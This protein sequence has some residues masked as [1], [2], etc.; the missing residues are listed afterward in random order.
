MTSTINQLFS[1][2]SLFVFV[3]SLISFLGY[4]LKKDNKITDFVSRN[5]ILSV[6]LLSTT[7]VIG[8]LTYSIGLG[9]TPCLLCWYQRIFM[10]PIALLSLVSISFNKK[11]D[12]LFIW[13]LILVGFGF[14]L[15]HVFITYTGISPIPCPA[16]ISCTVRYVYEFGFMTIP[17]MSF[18]FF[19]STILIMLTK[20]KVRENATVA[21]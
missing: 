9:F 11:I 21:M 10:F 3:I 7:A 14:S 16:E 20:E 5:K 8:S 1:F 12:D 18:L 19:V 13:A 6:A 17:L 4:K 15:Y 2:G